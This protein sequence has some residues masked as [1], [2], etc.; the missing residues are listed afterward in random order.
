MLRDPKSNYGAITKS[1]SNETDFDRTNVQY[2]EFWLMDPFIEGENGRVL[3]GIFNRNNTTG[4]KLVINLGNVSEDLMKDNIHAFEN[5]LSS[6]YSNTGI[7][8]NE[9]GRVTSKQYLTKFFEN[10]NIARDNQD[11]GLDG[12]KNSEEETHFKETFIDKLSLTGEGLSKIKNDVSADNFSYYLG[13]ELDETNKKIL[14]RYK[15]FNGMDG[16]TPLLSNSNFSL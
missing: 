10:N 5:G 11:V 14:E 13:N 2:I 15:N 12:L 6:D 4:G 9:W 16:N 3:D 1:I 7:D 8:V